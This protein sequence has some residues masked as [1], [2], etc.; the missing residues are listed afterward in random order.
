MLRYGNKRYQ[1]KLGW[2]MEK[3]EEMDMG[4]V[5]TASKSTTTRLCHL[6]HNG[7]VHNR[8]VTE[9]VAGVAKTPGI[10]S[11]NR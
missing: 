11:S 4:L 8:I 6:Y 10:S 2:E 5:I 7:V 1:S 3:T 9:L